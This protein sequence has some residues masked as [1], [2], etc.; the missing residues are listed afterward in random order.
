MSSPAVTWVIKRSD[1]GKIYA[2]ITV[3]RGDIEKKFRMF[4]GKTGVYLKV[5]DTLIPFDK[6]VLEQYKAVVDRLEEEQRA[7]GQIPRSNVGL[8]DSE[9]DA[10][11]RRV[12]ELLRGQQPSSTPIQR[13]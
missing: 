4:R 5:Q 10:I 7:S 2:E 9:I 3:K 6:P 12:A 11:A 13:G 8:S 1:A